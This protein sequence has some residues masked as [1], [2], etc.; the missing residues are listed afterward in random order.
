MD[1][2]NRRTGKHATKPRALGLLGHSVN[3]FKDIT[4]FESTTQ[5]D[6]NI[7]QRDL[8]SDYDILMVTYKSVHLEMKLL[9][10]CIHHFKI[11]LN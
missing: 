9:L 2:N 1:L 3:A 7:N 11:G 8:N 4:R 6:T 10:R 5:Y